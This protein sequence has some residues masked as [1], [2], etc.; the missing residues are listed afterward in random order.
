M[1]SGVEIR[2]FKIGSTGGSGGGEI[3]SGAQFSYIIDGAWHN[4][5]GKIENQLLDGLRITTNASDY[6]LMYRTKNAG[7]SGYYPSV[8]SR[9]S[10]FAG[11]STG[12]KM[13][14]LQIKAH[15]NA[16]AETSDVVVMYR[17]HADFKWQPWV[18]SVNNLSIMQSIQN[19][20]GLDGKLDTSSD[21]FAGIDG[22]MVSG[23]EIR[24][25]RQGSTGG[26]S[27]ETPTGKYKIIDAPFIAQN[28]K[29]PTGC[30]SVSTVMALNYIGNNI[31]VD[32]FIDNY[33][34]MQPYPFDPNE[35]FGG[36][37]RDGGSYGCYAPVIQKALNK[38]LPNTGYSSKVLS[39][40]SLQELCS[41]YIDNNIPVIMWATMSMRKPYV[42]KI[43]NYNNRV[44]NWIAPEHCLL[45]VGYDDNN[46]IFNDP[47]E[48]KQTYYSKS[49]VEAAYDG[50]GK[51]AIILEKNEPVTPPY[52]YER[53]SIPN[54]KPEN[55]SILSLIPQF[56]EL[57]NLYKQYHDDKIKNEP[58][59]QTTPTHIVLGM[60]NF[61]RSQQY[62][63]YEWYFTTMR[64]IDTDFVNRVKQ[65]VP[66]GSDK[67][68]FEQMEPYIQK[69]T[70]LLVSDGD[71]GLIDLAH[72]AATIDAYINEGLPPHFWAGWGGDLATGMADTT[73]S[74]N[75][76]VSFNEMQKMADRIIGNEDSSCNYSDFCS[77]FDA[78][79]IS[80]KIKESYGT[81]NW[82]FH[83][84]SDIIQSYYTNY[85]PL[86]SNRFKWITE[87]LNCSTDLN[88]L[89]DAIYSAMNGLDERAPLFGLLVLKA[90]NPSDKVNKACCNSFS[91]Y[92][93]SI[94]N[95]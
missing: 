83:I 82:N 18:C 33:L 39:N 42:S 58:G 40:V 17:V 59:L 9:G 26:G 90:N 21:D 94:L 5:S 23:V 73:K 81:S 35:T 88:S 69:G 56:I 12:K 2:I 57:E 61:I 91:N 53:P 50:L 72:M 46:Y 76:N 63:E 86:F 80:T 19:Q 14:L 38:I 95:E 3:T 37:P 75:P 64:P 60:V 77:D 51:Q 28:P 1:V 78:Y 6:Y 52:I 7:E 34:D 79:K 20:Y 24:I 4:F 49:S 67:T 62:D 16:G 84:F 71:R 74:I 36:N 44:I 10:D 45:L 31:S 85:Y 27:T 66:T 15:N 11:S 8:S 87:E 55:I 25:F 93:Y 48:H 68:L 92:I 89:K 22:Y 13:H 29:W 54:V 47:L 70:R 43:W 65:H 32:T 41:K 30:E